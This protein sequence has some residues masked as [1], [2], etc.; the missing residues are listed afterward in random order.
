MARRRRPARSPRAPAPRADRVGLLAPAGGRRPAR[1]SRPREQHV[2]VGFVLHT[3][4]ETFD[5]LAKLVRA[6][7][8]ALLPCFVALLG[9]RQDLFGW[10]RGGTQ[11]DAEETERSL[12]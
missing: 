9:Q 1:A 3:P 2:A 6:R 4:A 5:L 11:V 7:E 8:I 10:R 12:E